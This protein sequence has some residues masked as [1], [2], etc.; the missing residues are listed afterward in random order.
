MADLQKPFNDFPLLDPIGHRRIHQPSLQLDVRLCTE[1][2]QK[3]LFNDVDPQEEQ[4][5]KAFDFVSGLAY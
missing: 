4:L 2:S 3:G 1:Y 5:T